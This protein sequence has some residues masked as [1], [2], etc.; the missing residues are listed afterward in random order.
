MI[1]DIMKCLDDITDYDVNSLKE[2]VFG[3]DRIFLLGNGGSNA[4]ASHIMVDYIKFL[5]KKTFAFTD[6]SQ[7][8]AYCN[9]YSVDLAFRQYLVDMDINQNDLVILISS[10]GNSENIYQATNYC[11]HQDV[12][13]V[14]LTGFDPGNRVRFKFGH[15]AQVNF[16]V[17]SKS[18]GVV[19]N[20]H[21]IFLHSI[22]DN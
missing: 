22:V 20:V 21:Q 7:L 8:T 4:V 12:P 17:D 15:A 18:Y 13:F 2:V 9:D 14:L 3:C 19:E 16:W 11:F 1:Y 5:K 10:S 6:A